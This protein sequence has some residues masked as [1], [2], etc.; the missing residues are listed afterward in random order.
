MIQEIIETDFVERFFFLMAEVECGKHF[1]KENSAHVDWLKKR[2]SVHY[3]SGARFYAYSLEEIVPVG[4][5]AVLMDKGLEGVPCFGQYAEILDIGI[6]SEYRGKGYGTKLIEFSENV[7]RKSGA[8]CLGVF[9]S[10]S[11]RDAIAFYGKNGF[12]TA[13]TLPDVHGPNDAGKV[14]MRKIIRQ[15]GAQP[16]LPAVPR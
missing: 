2:I 12:L 1:H 11:D 14:W 13:A 10:A 15:K 5:I 7:A 4:F 3:F 16:A 9:T 6:F 8:Y